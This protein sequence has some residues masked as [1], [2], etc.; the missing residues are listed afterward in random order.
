MSSIYQQKNYYQI[1]GTCPL[2]GDVLVQS[3]NHAMDAGCRAIDTAQMYNNESDV[4]AFLK[5]TSIPLDELCVT[6]KVH[7]DNYTEDKFI[8]SVRES[9]QKLGMDSVDCLLMHW[10][11]GT[12]DDIAENLKRLQ[13]AYDLGLAKNIGVSNFTLAML[14]L[15]QDVLAVPVACN[16]VEFQPLLEQNKLLNG[17]KKMGI[18]LTAYCPIIRGKALENKEIQ[19][20]A[21]D[22]G[23]TPAQV[24]LRW[25]VQKGVGYQIMSTNPVNIKNNYDLDDFVLSAE[26]MARIDVL[27]KTN[28]RTSDGF[29]APWGSLPDWD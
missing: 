19:S 5:Q 22:I 1:F 13:Q 15:A 27:S 21:Q 3:L 12:M 6:T 18:M 25:I 11:K 4:G 7:P 23:K 10:P 24:V 16:Q 14:E 8:P 9:L 17:A 20:I 28:Y 29:T 26:H 2:V